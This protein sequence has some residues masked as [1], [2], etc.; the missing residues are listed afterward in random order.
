MIK[1]P[2]YSVV[3]ELLQSSFWFGLTHWT[4][5]SVQCEHPMNAQ[6]HIDIK[7]MMFTPYEKTVYKKH[8]EDKKYGW[9]LSQNNYVLCEQNW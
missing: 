6:P 3:W 4:V 5:C 9:Q 7:N 8:R 2:S 1:E